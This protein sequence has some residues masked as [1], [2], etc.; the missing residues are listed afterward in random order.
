MFIAFSHFQYHLLFQPHRFFKRDRQQLLPYHKES[1]ELVFYRKTFPIHHDSVRLPTRK[2]YHSVTY[3]ELSTA[4]WLLDI[5]S[6]DE[7][8]DDRDWKNQLT[9][10]EIEE[11][12]DVTNSQ[13]RFFHIWNSFMT[14]QREQTIHTIPTIRQ[15]PRLL[16]SFVREQHVDARQGRR[17]DTIFSSNQEL[18]QEWICH[19]TNLYDEVYISQWHITECMTLYNKLWKELAERSKQD[20]YGEGDKVAVQER[21]KS[22]MIAVQEGDKSGM[23]IVQDGDKI[24]QTEHEDD[25]GNKEGKVDQE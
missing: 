17:D 9:Q 21:D 23:A 20:I 15:L 22:I 8:D 25:G 7:I 13:K 19:L 1:S 10:H 14:R 24:D 16:E 5:D 4:E 11:Y 2:Y 18:Q 6:E 12:T 3:Q